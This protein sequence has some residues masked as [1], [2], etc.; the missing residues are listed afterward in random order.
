MKINRNELMDILGIK[1]S[2]LKS[3]I[4]R[5]QLNN[6]L[7]EKG[8]ELI[9]T[10]KE[11]RKTL[12]EVKE[13]NNSKNIYNGICK[14]MFKTK[15]E[16]EF[17]EYFFTRILNTSTPITKELISKKVNV[18]KNTLTKWDN[19]MVEN[20]ILSLPS[21]EINELNYFYV[22]CDFEIDKETL[23]QKRH[24]RLTDIR[25]YKNFMRTNKNC[26]MKDEVLKEFK[27]GNLTE[28]QTVLLL[29]GITYNQIA[30]SQKIVYRV[31]KFNLVK[32]NELTNFI[33]ELIKELYI[34]EEDVYK[35]YISLNDLE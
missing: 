29:D 24:Y 35:Y 33:V 22:A 7:I 21:N 16:Q 27:A 28:D 31:N 18:N 30:K 20:G 19:K 26:N 15:K 13:I 1:N 6:R 14:E 25:E 32:N 10:I 2:G 8:Y 23:T 12:Y 3:I 17:A 4:N 34:K 9:E 11:G 5:G